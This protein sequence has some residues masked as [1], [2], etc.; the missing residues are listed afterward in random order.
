MTKLVTSLLIL[1]NYIGA[2]VNVYFWVKG[3]ETA[4]LSAAVAVFAFG[5]AQFLTARLDEY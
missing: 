4:S 1:A 2:A 5:T 3:G